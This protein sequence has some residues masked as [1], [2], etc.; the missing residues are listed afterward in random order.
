MNNNNLEGL[1]AI[2]DKAVVLSTVN[3]DD[4]ISDASGVEAQYQKHVKTFIPLGD[5]NTFSK[6]LIKWVKEAKTPKGLITA[7]YGYGKTSTLA[8]LWNE[9]EKEGLISVPPF[10]CSNLLDVLKATYGWVKYKLELRQPSLI[11]DLDA[12]YKKYTSATIDEMAEQYA[13]QHGIAK[14]TARSMFVTMQADGKLVLEINPSNLLF[15]LDATSNLILRAGYSGLVLLP[16]E[17]QQYFS[18]GANLRR[19]VQEF[20]EFIWGLDTRSN[21]LGVVF[22]IPTYAE[23]VVQ[24]HG[25]DILARLKKDDLYYRL[26]DIY[27]VDFPKNLWSRYCETFNLQNVTQTVIDEY[28]LS[29]IGQI[30]ERDDLGEGPRTVIDSFKRAIVCFTDREKSY[31]P[32][33]LIDDFLNSHIQFQAQTNKIKSVTRQGLESTI[34]TSIDLKNAIKLLAAFPR[35]CSKEIQTFYN[36]RKYVVELSHKAHGE[37][38]VSLSDGETLLG[39]NRSGG[40]THIVDII[41]TKFWQTYEEDELHIESAINAFQKFVLPRCFLPRKGSGLIGWGPISFTSSPNGGYESLIDGS[42]NSQFPHRLIS[43]QLGTKY[44]QLTQFN[45]NVDLQFSFLFLLD[46]ETTYS[47]IEVSDYRNIRIKVNLKQKVGV[48]L[49]DDIRKLQEFVLPDYVTPL[50][51]LSLVDFFNKWNEFGEQPIQEA[52]RSEIEH[53]SGRLIGQA[54]QMV[55][56]RKLSE[57]ISPPL[58]KVGS[59]IFEELFNRCCEKLFSSYKTFYVHAHFQN[60]FNDYTNAM[61]D[62]SLKERRGHARISG[63]KESIGLRFSMSSVANFENRLRNEYCNL[64]TIEEWS[65]RG[66]QAS[67]SIRLKLH[68][69]EEVILETLKNSVESR[70]IDGKTVPV[71]HGKEIEMVGRSLGYRDDELML[72]LQL[73]IA[74]GY[75]R[76]DQQEKVI[77]FF[78][79]GPD[80][81]DLERRVI[82]LS[83]DLEKVSSLLEDNDSNSLRQG[84]MTIGTLLNEYAEDEENLDEISTKLTDLTNK[85]TDLLNTTKNSTK[86]KISLLIFDIDKVIISLKQNSILDREIH[87]QVAFVMHLNE[88]RQALVSHRRPIIERASELRSDLNKALNDA[89]NDPIAGTVNLSALYLQSLK[90]WEEIQSSKDA[91]IHRSDLLDKWIKL[92]ENTDKLF[93][94]L[95]SV[96]ELKENLTQEIVPEIL[97]HLTKRKMDGLNDWEVFTLRIQAVEEDLENLRRYGNE[98]FNKKKEEYEMFLRNIN[99][100]DFRPKCR[101]TYGEDQESYRDLYEEVR[102]KVE[103][104]IREIY[105]ELEKNQLDLLKAQ[106]IYMI[107]EKNDVITKTEAEI[108]DITLKL[109]KSKNLLSTEYIKANG[110]ELMGYG[111]GLNKLVNSLNE[112]QQ[113]LRSIIRADYKLN[114]NENQIIGLV[115]TKNDIDLTDLFVAVRQSGK[116]LDLESLIQLL[117]SLYRKNRIII[118]IRNR[119]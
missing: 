50:L 59:S 22:S 24:E 71:L 17:L 106:F 4:L 29:A 9:C 58:N 11:S 42:F 52:D 108:K 57:S 119:G 111:D 74:R 87:G 54:I 60:I 23:G 28:T 21:S 69:L 47:Q 35:G 55:F 45:E 112:I 38:I 36:L 19:I 2:L 20:R 98:L 78:Q 51:L 94:A 66:D 100:S 13:T 39:L 80:P 84:L 25:K 7:P 113:T 105:I 5:T 62:L 81:Q 115:K 64:A 96:P 1:Q 68:P 33:D 72:A 48:S 56:N 75:I 101:Y 61:R 91:L 73:L 49:P 82:K 107:D 70:L 10:Y 67:A 44:D 3:A 97:S 41:I 30:S 89:G 53:L 83:H 93:N 26:Q 12:I 99:V 86:Q 65:G 114:E 88:L 43:L 117:E 63:T 46:Q 6:K 90:F 104:R 8:F 102:T 16:D 14:I 85:F 31:T 95:T 27:T 32:M 77:F 118:R 40:P 79:I 103:S 92:L 110:D 15:F 116:L 76:L 37:L 109:R 34:V 18:R